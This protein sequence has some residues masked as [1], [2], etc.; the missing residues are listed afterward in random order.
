MPSHVSPS[1]G[2]PAD[3]PAP[4]A[5]P[6]PALPLF[7]KLPPLAV[8]ICAPPLPVAEAPPLPVVAVPPLLVAKAPPLLCVASPW[9][10]P[11]EPPDVPVSPSACE[12]RVAPHASAPPVSSANTN[13]FAHHTHVEP[14]LTSE[15]VRDTRVRATLIAPRGTPAEVTATATWRLA[16]ALV[17]HSLLR[18]RPAANRTITQVVSPRGAVVPTEVDDLQVESAASFLSISAALKS[19]DTLSLEPTDYTAAREKART[20]ERPLLIDF[21]ASW[22]VSCKELEK[23]TFFDDE[24]SRE[25]GRFVAV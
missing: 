4:P 1:P 17:D 11:T 13:D 15:S 2:A 23:V 22:C 8:V 3:A 5:A 20:Q 7:D 9:P 19:G 10:P 16:P 12:R 24:V 21:A 25:P 6:T 14:E 18:C